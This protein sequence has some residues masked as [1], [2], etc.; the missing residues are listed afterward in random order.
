[1]A[2]NSKFTQVQWIY[3]ITGLV[4]GGGIVAFVGSVF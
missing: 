4:A 2:N 3:F 1:M